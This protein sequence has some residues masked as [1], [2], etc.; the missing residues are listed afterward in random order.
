MATVI[1]LKLFSAR[2]Q[3]SV[4]RGVAVR[5]SVNKHNYTRGEAVFYPRKRTTPL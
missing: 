5:L 4:T 1:P 3:H 2:K